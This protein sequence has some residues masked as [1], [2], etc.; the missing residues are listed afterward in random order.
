MLRTNGDKRALLCFPRNMKNAT[1]AN[2]LELRRIGPPPP[3]HDFL[4][5]EIEQDMICL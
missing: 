3:N 2:S 4:V 1:A 5:V